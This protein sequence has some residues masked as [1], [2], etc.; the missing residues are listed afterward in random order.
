[1]TRETRNA[2]L[3]ARVKVLEGP[4]GWCDYGTFV[5]LLD[6]EVSARDFCEFMAEFA[7]E[8]NFPGHQP[9]IYIFNPDVRIRDIIDYLYLEHQS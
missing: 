4:F 5:E 6:I 9:V 7:I 2:L 3:E 8:V 1:M